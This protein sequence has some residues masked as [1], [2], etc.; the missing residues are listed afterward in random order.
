MEALVGIMI[1][2]A[3]GLF[4]IAFFVIATIAIIYLFYRLISASRK[5]E[6]ER[7][8]ALKQL[9][10]L[11]GLTHLEIRRDQVHAALD[12]FRVAAGGRRHSI[13]NYLTG[14]YQ[15]YAMT[16]FDHY[17]ASGSGDNTTHYHQSVVVLESS[18]AHL[19]RFT[20]LSEGLFSKIGD[21]FS[22]KDIDFPNHPEFS[23]KYT[24]KGENPD[25]IRRV[26]TPM[27][28]N[29]FTNNQGMHVEGG[30]SM[31]TV[32]RWDQ[33]PPVEEVTRF[34]DQGIEILQMFAA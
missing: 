7:T 26:F 19:P 25:A 5:K 31:L 32:Y 15:G 33:R 9:A 1:M 30:G 21:L 4:I 2:L 12:K 3:F 28:L 16:F 22:Q 18:K 29:Y 34:L 24:L 27:I 20:L 10:P 17:Y 23:R 6:A 13:W 14:E 8:R 11:L